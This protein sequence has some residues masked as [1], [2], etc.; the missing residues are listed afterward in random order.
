M[1]DVI[2][3]GGGPVGLICTL[4]LAQAGVRV[5]VIEAESQIISS[6]RAALYF[7][8][9]LDGLERLGILQELE[10]DGLR[11]Q[12]YTY[13]VRRS[14][15]RVVYSMDILKGRAPHPYNLHLGQHLLAG[16]AL[17]RLNTLPN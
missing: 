9:V 6:P 1:Q 14:G 4:G 7:W 12:D 10:A 3:V 2:I 15:E 5:C 13:L 16:I 11:K 17:R 8:S